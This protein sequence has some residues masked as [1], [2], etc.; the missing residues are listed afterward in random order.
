VHHD[1]VLIKGPV[2]PHA[3]LMSFSGYGLQAKA[4]MAATV[5]GG[6]G[7]NFFWFLFTLYLGELMYSPATIGIIL[8]IMGFTSTLPL[9]PAGYLGDRFGR[10]RMILIGLAMNVVSPIIVVFMQG[11]LFLCI[12]AVLWG[13]GSSFYGPSFLALMAE[14]VSDRKRKYLFS[15]QS[16]VGMISGA[17]T[18]LVAGFMP[19]FLADVA[20]IALTDG[21]RMTFLLGAIV[22]GL[23]FPILL[24][25]KEERKEP[26][27]F[28]ALAK[29]KVPNGREIPP[30]PWKTLVMLCLPMVLI[31]IGAGLIVPF[32]Q[33]YFIWRFDTPVEIIG[34]LFA[35]TQFFWGL[36][37][38][39][40]PYVSDSIGSV[41]AIT[42]VQTFAIFALVGIPLS[43]SFHFVAVMYVIRMVAM[44]SAWPILQSYS[45]GQV[46]KEHSSFTLS[47][48]NFCFNVP[49]G[50][51]PGIAGFI[52]EYNL[53]VPFFICAAFYFVSTMLFF[54]VFKNRDDKGAPFGHEDDNES[55][56]E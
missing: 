31:G 54:A 41:R 2:V 4:M 24:T 26:L 34:I 36:A 27:T 11:F 6:I 38:L 15:L 12:G 50:L 7:G 19:R 49:K 22:L 30:I 40:M 25:L 42:I 17:C 5:L 8:M 33:L 35:I 3:H 56:E 23:Q 48:T 21:Y 51:T 32:F 39:I 37:Y 47:A 29:G 43:P 55:E 14:K 13:F 45:I 10:R 9:L 28:K 46:P 52:Y 16:F 18:L 53:D 44:N 1:S 20:N